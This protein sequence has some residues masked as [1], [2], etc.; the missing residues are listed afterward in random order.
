[1]QKLADKLLKTL[2]TTNTHNSIDI[3]T[4]VIF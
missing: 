3:K 4:M 1:M 2:K